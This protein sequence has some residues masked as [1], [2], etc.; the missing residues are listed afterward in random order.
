MM[1][2]NARGLDI[3]QHFESF[4][5]EPYLCPSS[6][7]TIGYGTTVINGEPVNPDEDTITE[8][9]ACE[10]LVHDLRATEIQ[11]F[12]LVKVPLNENQFSALCSFVYNVGSGNFAASTLR[13]K[14]NRGDYEGAANEFWK[15]RRG[16]GKILKG[17]VRRREAEKLLFIDEEAL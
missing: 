1:Q 16:G 6:V 8:N 15:W 14:L 4:R 10:L 17:L 12:H 7:W 5:P 3:I 9:E 11:V 13:S 2:T